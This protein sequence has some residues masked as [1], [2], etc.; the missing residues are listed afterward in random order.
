MFHVL[1]QGNYGIIRDQ[2]RPGKKSL[3]IK[4]QWQITSTRLRVSEIT[5]RERT[6]I[7]PEMP[8]AKEKLEKHFCENNSKQK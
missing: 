8:A 3:V 1:Y 2:V 7:R 6:A 5:I 4:T